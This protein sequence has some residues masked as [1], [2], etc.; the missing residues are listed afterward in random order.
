M[1]VECATSCF[2]WSPE[3]NL[4]QI[5]ISCPVETLYLRSSKWVHLLLEERLLIKNFL[6][7][8]VISYASSLHSHAWINSP[9]F[10]I[11]VLL[12][13]QFRWFWISIKFPKK[14]YKHVQILK[15][16]FFGNQGLWLR[17]AAIFNS[18]WQ[19]NGHWPK[20]ATNFSLIPRWYDYKIWSETKSILL[21]TLN[22]Y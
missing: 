4:S 5:R 19:V 20:Y 22:L 10:S 15:K 6:A 17:M 21:C 3:T 18:I 9:P 14:W 12:T 7:F 1:H 8:T 2:R 11:D 16:L 13:A